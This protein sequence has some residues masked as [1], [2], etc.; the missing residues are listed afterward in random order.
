MIYLTAINMY[1]SETRHVLLDVEIIFNHCLL[2][3]NVQL[4]QGQHRLFFQF[5]QNNHGRLV[6]P[7][8]KNLSNDLLQQ[9]TEYYYQLLP[10]SH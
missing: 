2:L 5:P 9:I 10:D 7:L 8:S 1:L 4:M 3:K 6:Y